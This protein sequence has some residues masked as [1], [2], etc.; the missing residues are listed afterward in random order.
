MKYAIL[1]AGGQLGQAFLRTLGDRAVGFVRA[2][3]DLARP[4][5]LRPALESAR[6]DV[7]INCAAYNHVDQAESDPAGAFAVNAWGV[8][9]LAALCQ[10]LDCVLVHYSTNYVF[11]LDRT[12]RS[13]YLE[14][15]LPAPNSVY[16][17]SKL[18]GEAL[19][20]SY[21]DKHFIIRTAALYGVAGPGTRRSFVELM[22]HLAR[23]KQKIRVVSD[24]VVAPTRTEDL[25]AATLALL[26]TKAYGLYH[27]TSTG[28]C[29]WHDYAG[30]IF[31]LAGV[32]ATLTGVTS[33]EYGAAAPR[34][35][36]SVL[37]NAAYDRLGLP[38]MR[39]WRS[40]LKDYLSSSTPVS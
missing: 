13:P 25:A 34:P 32:D 40:A 28:E 27:L 39:D 4:Q 33:A 21:C 1:G 15:D 14:S 35:S 6:P 5:S 7:V 23:Q 31:K 22:L 19:A 36:Y 12:R 20:R 11:G 24:Q 30:A 37:A 8:R 16:G 9:D 18:A 2:Q 38:A 17:A 29:T 26:E 10:S 3:A